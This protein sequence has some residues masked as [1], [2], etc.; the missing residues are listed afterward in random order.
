MHCSRHQTSVKI[1][2]T[3]SF[4]R[5]DQVLF[6]PHSKALLPQDT[7]ELHTPRAYVHPFSKCRCEWSAS[8]Y[9]TAG[10]VS[11]SQE[12]TTE[13]LWIMMDFARGLFMKFVYYESMKR[14]LI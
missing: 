11:M 13:I 1:I 4:L 3:W 8:Y 7:S 12:Y 9:P 2:W 6:F 10:G 14:K 5:D